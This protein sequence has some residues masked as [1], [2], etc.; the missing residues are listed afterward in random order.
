MTVIS[1]LKRRIARFDVAPQAEQYRGM[2][3]ADAERVSRTTAKVRADPE[4]G[5]ALEDLQGLAAKLA[6]RLALQRALTFVDLETTGL[7]VAGDRIVEI[8][9]VRVEPTGEVES[10]ATLVNPA[11]AIP[12]PATEVHGIGDN[13]VAEAPTF[14]DVATTLWGWL[15]ES[16]LGGYNLARFD[17]PMLEAEFERAGRRFEWH[18]ARIIDACAIFKQMERRDLGAAYRFYCASDLEGDHTASAD[19]RATIEV[20]LGQLDHYSELPPEVAGL[21]AVW[22]PRRR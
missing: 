14:A 13:D 18:E 17:L 9:L 4:S 6:A 21:D 19:V 15:A 7:D 2:A 22:R 8:A 16:D 20:V 11:T 1:L 10:F 12:P 5:E 3:D